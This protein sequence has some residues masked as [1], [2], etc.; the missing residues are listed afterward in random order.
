MDE[1]LE[2]LDA[3]R[4]QPVF[5]YVHTMDSHSP[6]LPPPP[7]D[8]K[9]EP[10]PE[11][12]RAAAE[13]SDYRV[14]LDRDRIVAQYDGTIAYGDQ[15]FGRFV[16]G[17]RERGVYDSALVVFVADHGEEFLDHRGWVHGHTL[18]DELVR[19]PLVVKYPG[20]RDAGRRVLG[21]VQ[22]VDVLPTIL[23]SQGMLPAVGIAGQPLEESFGENAPQRVAVLET[24]YREFVAYGARTSAAKYVRNLYP[25]RSE[26][27]FDLA[28]RSA[29]KPKPRARFE[30][31]GRGAEADGR[32]GGS[33]RPPS[34]T[35][36]VPKATRT[37]SFGCGPRAGSTSSSGWASTRRSARRCWRKGSCWR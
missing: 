1:A 27:V 5:L 2:F 31:R 12:G 21:Q 37:T 22:L 30:P 17:L 14:P 7:F 25:G 6:Y 4:G 15:E 35:G 11:P 34:A 29:R 18:F 24:K 3:R 9:Y 19:V 32:S 16:Q 13:P 33:P 20:R 23:K 26:L 36:C 28:G 8:R 10:H